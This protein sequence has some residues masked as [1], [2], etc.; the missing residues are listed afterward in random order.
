M[1]FTSYAFAQGGPG[2]AEGPV[3]AIVSFF[4]LILIFVIFYFLLIR[5]QQ[6]K[7]KEHREMT[8]NLKKGEHVIT[9]GGIH[10][11]ITNISEETVT[12]EVANQVRIKVTRSHIASKK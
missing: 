1:F 7:A 10:G 6:K 3:P 8:A 5:P 12:L 11:T 4:P 2:G 9:S